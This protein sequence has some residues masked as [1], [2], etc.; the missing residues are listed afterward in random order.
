MPQAPGL[1][2]SSRDVCTPSVLS[3][4]DP[5]MGVGSHVYV[6]IKWLFPLVNLSDVDL[7]IRP[8]GRT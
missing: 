2:A 8:S 4:P 7:T 3:V 5:L 6:C 1:T